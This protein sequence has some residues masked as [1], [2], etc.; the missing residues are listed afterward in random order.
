METASIH[1]HFFSDI[2][3]LIDLT[4]SFGQERLSRTGCAAAGL[5]QTSAA[6]AGPDQGCTGNWVWGRDM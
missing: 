1:F 4:F 5:H 3:S 2:Y 6:S